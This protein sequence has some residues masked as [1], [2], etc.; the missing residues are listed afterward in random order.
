MT[1]GTTS[2]QQIDLPSLVGLSAERAREIVVA[3]GGV[4]RT[5]APDGVV[6]ADFRPN[7]VT[8]VVAAG[9]VVA[10]PRFG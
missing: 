1:S 10:E 5:V 6:T 9:R 4:T 2:W 8:L 7:R 3:A